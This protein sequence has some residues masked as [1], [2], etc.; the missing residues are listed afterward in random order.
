MV[1]LVNYVITELDKQTILQPTLEYSYRITITDNVGNVLNVLDDVVPSSLTIS[2]DD[3][4]RRKIDV[5]IYN[6]KNVEEW[7]NLYMRMN[8]VFEIGVFSYM[9]G[10]Y[11]W[12]PCGTYVITDSSTVY[13]ASNNTLSTILMDWFAKMDGTRNGQVG[14]APTIVIQQNDSEGN[15]ITIQKA[16]RNF[17][18]AEQIT[19]K[20]LLEDIGEF[21][22]Q[23][24]TNPDKYEEY[25][26]NNPDWNKMPYDLEFSAG[27]TQATMV[28]GITDLYPNIQ[29]YFDVYNNFCCNMIPSCVN[30]PV[31]LDND[32]LQSVLVADNSESTSYSLSSIKNVT[33]VFGKSYEVD[34]DADDKCEMTDNVFTLTLDKYDEYTEYQIIAFKPK[35]TNFADNTKVK[36][37]S[38]TEIPVYNEYSTTPIAE[39]T[40]IPNEV[41]TIMIRKSNETWISYYLGQYQPH[42]LCV[43][44]GDEN[45]TKYTRKYFEDKFNCKNLT[46]RVEKD[47]PYTIQKIGEVLDVKTGDEF[48][49]IISESVTAQNAV[50]FNQKSSS[51]NETIEI[52]TKMLPW[53]DCNVKVEYKK[54]NSNEIKQY[55]VKDISHD[56]DGCIS[57]ITLQRFYPL[58]Y[59]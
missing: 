37:N 21:Y 13:D 38:L 4:T 55:I 33:E 53:I 26:K 30:D 7:L 51:M 19:D 41:N 24:S 49:N 32:F 5:T 52:S 15:T 40:F 34:R 16:L 9:K 22:G 58:Y 3:Q 42:A 20:L 43:L 25:R 1:V 27:D 8:F 11:I 50:Y 56:L 23:Q 17:M 2:P 14:G 6:V 35:V 36:I 44:T 28:A 12:Y 48:D 10:D 31:V 39:G 54:A 46:F 45:D 29:A 59:V 47:S 18:T 57:T